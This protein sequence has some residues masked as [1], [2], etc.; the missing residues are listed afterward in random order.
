LL[1]LS[2][3]WI[4]SV[5]VGKCQHSSIILGLLASAAILNVKFRDIES[6]KLNCRSFRE[7]SPCIPTPTLRVRPGAKREEVL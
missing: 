6:H 1:L 7:E 3:I 2:G 4:D 5:T